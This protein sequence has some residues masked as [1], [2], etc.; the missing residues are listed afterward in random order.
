M[1]L[2]ATMTIYKL[3]PREWH[4]VVEDGIEPYATYGLPDPA[5][6]VLI[7]AEE[8]GRILAVST[9]LEAVHNHWA[10]QPEARHSPALIAELWR[11]TKAVLDEA[12]VP[13]VHVTV[14]DSQA[15]VAA[16]VERL[17]YTPAEG[18]LYILDPARCLLNERG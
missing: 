9:L 10:I 7:V 4:R 6:A 17:G 14:A 18:T 8:D 5:H 13:T 11:H 3:D 2:G 12:A 16:M 1:G 15:D